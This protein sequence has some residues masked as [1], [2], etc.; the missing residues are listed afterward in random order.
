MI[1][2]VQ[3]HLKNFQFNVQHILLKLSGQ[4]K[5]D[6]EEELIPDLKRS[7]SLPVDFRHTIA[8]ALPLGV[9]HFFWWSMAIKYDL[10]QLFPERY[11]L[12]ITMIIAS[13]FAG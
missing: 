9:V 11:A 6:G 4:T 8:L 7:A 10:F 12:V 2:A 3:K 1:Y 5:Q 13:F